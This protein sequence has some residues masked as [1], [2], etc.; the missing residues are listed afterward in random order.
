MSSDP[1]GVE[2]T[3]GRTVVFATSGRAEAKRGYGTVDRV[4]GERVYLRDAHLDHGYFSDHVR[5]SN[6][7]VVELPEAP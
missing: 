4:T 2:I 5:A 3:P 6:V 1:R 7:Y